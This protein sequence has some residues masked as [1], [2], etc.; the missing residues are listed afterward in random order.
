[1]HRAL[2]LRP[3]QVQ[4]QIVH[5]KHDKLSSPI[6]HVPHSPTEP[7]FKKERS[8]RKY[9]LGTGCRDRDRGRDRF[10]DRSGDRFR[11]FCNAADGNVRK[12]VFPCAAVALKSGNC[13][14]PVGRRVAVLAR[15]QRAAAEIDDS[16][17]DPFAKT[18]C[19]AMRVPLSCDFE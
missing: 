18:H 17:S 7:F 4:N 8:L 11:S 10:R 3:C 6:I 1:M 5:L 14:S 19:M 13:R 9:G 2:Q 16:T 12:Y 15:S